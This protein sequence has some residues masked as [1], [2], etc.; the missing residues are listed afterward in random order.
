MAIY[1]TISMSFWTDNKVV[2][3]FTPEDRYFYLYLFTNPHTNLCGCYEVS[4]K[5]M[6]YEVGYS[7]DSINMLLKRFE[8]VHNVIRY[9]E[10]TKEVLLLNWHKYNWTTSEKFRKPLLKEISEVK[11]EPFRYYLQDLADGKETGYG[12]DTNCINTTV[13]VTDTD[14]VTNTAKTI[15]KNNNSK[16]NDTEES[17]ETISEIIEYLNA[18]IGSN[19][20]PN[21]AETIKLIHGRLKEGRTIDDFKYVIDV[22]AEEWMGTPQEQYLRPKTLFAQSNFE[23]YLQQRRGAKKNKQSGKSNGSLDWDELTEWAREKDR[24]I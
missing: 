9:S 1:R 16:T 17:Q 4:L 3:D 11:C 21:T 10:K 12:I 2:D 6:A 8:E 20:R 15:N 13:T 14:T 23:N 24:A 18:R 19:Y 22:K 7:I 5:Q